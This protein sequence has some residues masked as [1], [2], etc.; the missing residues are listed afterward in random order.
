MVA[1]SVLLLVG[2]YVLGALPFAVALAA[3]NGID[4]SEGDLHIALWY[5]V[6][7]GYAALAVLVDVAKGVFPVLIGYGFSLPVGVVAFSGVVATAGQM[8]PPLR[9]HGEKGNTTGMGALLVLLL[10]YQAYAG[11][12]CIGFFAVGA[13][14][15]YSELRSF[16]DVRGPAPGIGLLALPLCMLLGFASAPF[17][18]WLAN[19]P[20]GL[21]VGLLFIFLAIVLRRLTAGIGR[22]LAVGAKLGPILVRRVLFDES[23]VTHEW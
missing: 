9:G 4:P 17:F 7:P 13:A 19:E 8:W 15:R 1:G 2:A 11:L 23:L 21:T 22:D 3:A 12:L 14:L 20:T 18:I 6:G 16:T 5:K 10:A